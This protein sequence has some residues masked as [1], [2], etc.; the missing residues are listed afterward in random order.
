MPFGEIKLVPGVNVERTPT[1]NEAGISTSQLI[2]FKDALVQKYGGFERFYPLAVGG[3]PRELHAWQDLNG[4]D[5]LFVGSTTQASVISTG[6]LTPITP[7]TKSTD[8]KPLVIATALSTTI[9]IVDPNIDTVTTFDTVYF[10][11]PVS[12]GGVVLSGSYPIFQVAGT[13]SFQIQ[14]PAAAGTTNTLLTNATSAV[15]TT[16]INFTAVPAWVGT[17][18][19]L[20]A[21]VQATGIPANATVTSISG[22]Q[23]TITTAIATGGLDQGAPVVFTSLPR[24][25]TASGSPVVA[26]QLDAHGLSTNETV[27]FPASTTVSDVTIVGAYTVNSVANASTFAITVDVAAQSTAVGNMN[28]GLVGLFYYIT[29]GPSPIGSGYG[30]GPYGGGGYGTGLTSAAQTGTPITA[31][32]WT[33]DNWGQLLLAC[34]EGGGVYVFDPNGGFETLG[35]V[36]TA[37][38]FNGGIFVSTSQQMLVCWAS[39]SIKDIGLL[40]DPMVVRWSD[41]E[42]Y[43]QFVALSTNQAGSFRIPIGSKIMGG[44]AVLNQNMIW[45]DLDLW[46][47]NYQGQPFVWGFNKIGAGAGLISSHAAQQLRGAVYW[48]GLRNFY[49]FDGQGVRV[50]P[51]PVWDAVFQNLSTA[52]RSDGQPAVASVRAMPNTPFN[53]VGWEYPSSAS[54]TGENDSYVKFNVTEQGTPWDMGTLARSAWIDQTVL[55]MPIAAS[56]SGIIYQHETTNDADGQPMSAS[57]VTGYFY[58]SPGEDFVFV[59]QILPDFKWGFYG[60]AETAQVYLSI[61]VVDYPGD[62]P[63]VFGPYLMTESTKYISTRLR[64]R[65][66]SFTIQSSD[67]GS[68]WRIGKVRYR[69]AP[70]G[71]R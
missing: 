27:V 3:V 65:Q 14:V 62:T 37:P 9:T 1:L 49:V 10:E 70:D 20:A 22:T 8:F 23:V 18:M 13:T 7:Q 66:G 2:R 35:L 42:D 30:I 34:P 15:G 58:L 54:V 55:G 57:F 50:L 32:D 21:L 61:N 45:T 41:I 11:T 36:P 19:L 47:M 69:Y 39:T 16:L 25:T 56:P 46:V 33:S 51:C 68:W 71:R 52:T 5:H 63:Q 64:G 43:T 53:E 6:V 26:V 44:M 29:L 31:T 38:I 4:D 28:T 67:L 60:Q 59:D 12:A 17:G 40:Q 48:M 24:F